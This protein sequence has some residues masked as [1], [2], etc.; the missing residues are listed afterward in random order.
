MN[1]EGILA[2]SDFFSGISA[3]SLL[4]VSQICI[5]KNFEKH[6]VLFMEGYEGGSMHV[7]AAGQVQLYKTSADGRDVVIKVVGPGEV[8]GAVSYTHLRAHET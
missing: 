1:V 6:Q 3:K 2:R 4:A 8:F 5:P 7:V